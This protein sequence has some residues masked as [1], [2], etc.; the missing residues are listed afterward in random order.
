MK[1]DSLR[2][3]VEVTLSDCDAQEFG[4][5]LSNL[6]EMKWS[7]NLTRFHWSKSHVLCWLKDHSHREL[8]LNTAKWWGLH[9]VGLGVTWYI[10]KGKRYEVKR[11]VLACGSKGV[12][13]SNP[14]CGCDKLR[15]GLEK[16]CPVVFSTLEIYQTSVERLDCPI[17]SGVELV[18]G[19]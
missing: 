15:R 17:T 7:I 2:A 16:F 10:S 18:D 6:E 4:I 8:D 3:V 5:G 14:Y 9:E 19:A 11:L 13:Q 1:W 12:L